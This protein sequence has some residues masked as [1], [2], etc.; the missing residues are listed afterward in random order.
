MHAVSRSALGRD[1]RS[2]IPLYYQVM[3]ELKEQII[4][5][6]FS[7]GGR[8]PSE[9]DLTQRFKASRV[10]IRQALRILEEQALIVRV[11]GSGTF[12]AAA[13]LEGAASVIRGDPDDLA[14]LGAVGTSRVLG[15]RL[16]KATPDLAAVFAV[17]AG[18]DL[19][20]VER[21]WSVGGAPLAFLV[22]YLPYRVGAQLSVT[23]VARDPLIR[24]IER[25][26]GIRVDWASE[27]F[28]AVAADQRMAALLE[29]DM[30]APLLKLT[31][32]QYSS[33]AEAID[34]AHV[35]YRSDRYRHCAFLKRNGGDGAAFWCSCNDQPK[36]GRE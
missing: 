18:S 31:L 8:L 10:V 6:N 17:D 2:G 23:D 16:I 12:V 21:L 4:S 1:R 36:G 22:D 28:E 30:L 35:F 34:H 32:T 20:S 15:F 24:L 27:V 29:V 5:G 13:P 19:F 9:I 11:K 25:R 33:A 3:R 7:P 14:N 26:A